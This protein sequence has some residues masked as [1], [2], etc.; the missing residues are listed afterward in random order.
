MNIP[1]SQFPVRYSITCYLLMII[2]TVICIYCPVGQ[3]Q[4]ETS[5]L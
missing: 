3:S 4:T 2:F 5:G 1:V